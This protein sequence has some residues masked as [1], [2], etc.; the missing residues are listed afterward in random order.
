MNQMRQNCMLARRHSKASSILV[1]LVTL[2]LAACIKNVNAPDV[3]S[4]ISAVSGSEQFAAVGTA[5][6]NPL[7]VLVVDANGQPFP[8]GTVTWQVT[9]GG[10]TV[11]DSTTTADAHGHAS[12]TYTAGSDPGTAT[13]VAT[14]A[15]L[16]TASFTIHVV[17]P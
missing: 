5:A 4:G 6:A 15:Q 10:G 7:V 9:G 11:A 17:S 14:A 3:A 8:G 2:A 13:I 16:W 12:T 1:V